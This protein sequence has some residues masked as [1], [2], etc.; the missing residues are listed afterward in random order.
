MVGVDEVLRLLGE[1]EA[2]C[3]AEV[4]RLDAEQARLAGLLAD[5][6][7][8]L[9][10]LVVAREVVA[11]L[12]PVPPVAAV[13]STGGGV[14]AGESTEFGQQLLAILA[15]HP[16][17][18]RCREIVAAMGEDPK[19]ARHGERVRHRLKK[20]VAADLVL[21][22]VPGEFTLADGRDPAFR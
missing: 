21:E 4:E 9:E 7:V 3:R 11:G 15:A 18:M 19:V 12:A 13:A 14:P 10:R 16:S 6:R 5:C 22:A 8:E 20:L 17:P 2:M 1:Q